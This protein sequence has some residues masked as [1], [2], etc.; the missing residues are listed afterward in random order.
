[1][2]LEKEIFDI[3][4]KD[5]IPNRFQPREIFD[6]E[7]LNIYADNYKGVFRI[8]HY[9][10]LKNRREGKDLLWLGPGI[11]S[12]RLFVASLKNDLKEDEGLYLHK[13]KK[14]IIRRLSNEP[15]AD[16]I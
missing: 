2:N 10:D 3:S 12:Q 6:E 1:M 8:S 15:G 11:Y 14:A 16:Q 5:I 9:D 4:L 13:G 7:A